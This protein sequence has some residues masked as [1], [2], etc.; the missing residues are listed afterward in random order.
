[1]DNGKSNPRHGRPAK[2]T[3]LVSELEAADLG[4]P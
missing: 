1:M 2:T 3:G 4:T